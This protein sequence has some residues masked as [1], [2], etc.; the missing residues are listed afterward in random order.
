[1]TLKPASISRSA[2]CGD[3]ALVALALWYAHSPELA[4]DGAEWVLT[5]ERKPSRACE[6]SSEADPSRQ[7]ELG[8]FFGRGHR[9]VGFPHPDWGANSKHCPA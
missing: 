4:A 5:N 6:G 9:L 7:V 3:Q 1:M 8:N 2:F